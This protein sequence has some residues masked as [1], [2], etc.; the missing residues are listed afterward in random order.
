MK[1]LKR[2]KMV[3]LVLMGGAL[4]MR[5]DS[6]CLSE[7]TGVLPSLSLMLAISDTVLSPVTV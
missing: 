6:G 4:F 3:S 2:H 7:L 5:V 1:H